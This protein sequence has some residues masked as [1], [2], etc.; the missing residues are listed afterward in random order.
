MGQEESLLDLYGIA[1][2][3]VWQ[4][5]GSLSGYSAYVQECL[6]SHFHTIWLAAVKKH[7][8]P[9]PYVRLVPFI[10]YS[11]RACLF[12]DIP[13]SALLMQRS[14]ARLRCGLVKLGHKGGKH[15]TASVQGCISCC[16]ESSSLWTHVFGECPHWQRPRAEAAAGLSLAPGARSWDIMY[17]ILSCPSDSQAYV[18]CLSLVHN[19]VVAAEQF[20]RSSRH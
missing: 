2:F 18:V 6:E 17:G 4:E 19:V 13:W 10:P 1:D 3:P 5:G 16:C 20:W 11:L 12:S 7:C 14:L 8:L 9:V 15:T